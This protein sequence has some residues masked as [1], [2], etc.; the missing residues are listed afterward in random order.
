MNTQARKTPLYDEHLKLGARMVDF[1]GWM[2]PVQY[3]SIIDEHNC[4]RNQV[5]LFD[6]SHMGEV[7]VSGKDSVSFLQSIVPQD[8]SKLVVEKAVYCQLTNKNGGIIDDLIIYRLEDK[9]DYPYFLLIVNASRVENDLDWII[10]EKTENNYDVEIDNQSDNL[11]LL[12][13][14]GPDSSNLLND[15]GFEYKNQPE[16]FNIRKVNLLSKDVYVSRTGYTGED[17]FEILMKNEDA[18]YF[19]NELLEKGQKY[20]IKPIGLGARDT[21]R[22]EASLHLYGQDM[23][24][25]I[26]P[27]EA[28]LGWS[29]P[30]TKQEDYN[31]KQKILSQIENKPEKTLIGFKMLDRAIPRHDYEIYANGEKVGVVTSGGISPTLQENIGMGYVNSSIS[32]TPGTEIEIMVRN[33]L[34]KAEIVKRPFVKK[35]HPKLS[36]IKK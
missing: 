17:G 15:I 23:N 30:K 8:I 3:S 31:G 12:A 26:T 25:D 13:L 27:V 6:V 10:K 14:Q 22:L 7:F 35:S 28:S 19:W 29:I 18:V 2:M 34:Y 11:S 1:A 20:G 4:V 21:L 24:E 36:E 32:R 9:D 5:G 16:Y 33:K